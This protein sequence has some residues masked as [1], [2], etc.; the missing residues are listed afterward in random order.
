[1]GKKCD[2]WKKL[3]LLSVATVL[4]LSIVA[5]PAATH[6]AGEQNTDKK[7]KLYT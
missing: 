7:F 1:V 4:C 3:V 2:E 6:I 5:F